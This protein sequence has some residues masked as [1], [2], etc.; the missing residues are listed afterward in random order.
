MKNIVLKDEFRE[1]EI[2]PEKEFQHYLNLIRED[3]KNIFNSNAGNNFYYCPACQSITSKISF[4][5][6]GFI[7]RECLICKSIY[8]S[9]RPTKEMLHAFFSESKAMKYWNSQVVQETEDRKTHV[10]NPRIRWVEESIDFD[11]NSKRVF[12]DFYSKDTPFIKG[13][14]NSPNYT[15]KLAYKASYDIRDE[16]ENN[17]FELTEELAPASCSIITAFEVLIKVYSPRSILKI[18]YDSLEDNGLLFLTTTSASGF[19]IQFLKEQS[20]SLIPPFELNIFS[21]EGIIILLKEYNFQIIEISTPGSLDLQLVEKAID[22]I[23]VP[24]FIRDIVKNRK[25]QIK[26]EFQQFLQRSLL[27]SHLRIIAQ[28]IK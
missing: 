8:L 17:G 16:I 22:S 20:R 4:E 25:I 10:F 9:P 27:S 3:I 1:I 12:C 23:E 2:R 18:I 13:I 11:E 15:R 6:E 21:I 24:N 19:D 14:S 7:Y 28:K 26:E 5:K